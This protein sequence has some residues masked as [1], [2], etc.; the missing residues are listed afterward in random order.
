MRLLAIVFVL[1]AFLDNIAAALIGGAMAHTLFRGRV[2]VGYLAAIVA[3]SNAGGSGSVIGDTT[4][5][6]MWISGVPPIEVLH[7]YIAAAVAFL[8]FGFPAARAQQRFAPIIK[9]AETALV[10]DWP[11][12]AI[13]VLHPGERRR[14]QRRRECDAPGDSSRF[15]FIGAAVAARHRAHAPPGAGPTGASCRARSRDRSFCC[16]SS[17]PPR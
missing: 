8:V 17:P 6:M 3:A 10:I 11:R 7:A 9:D 14:R 5:T 15:P 1:S 16:A 4:T 2:R 12:V 13:V